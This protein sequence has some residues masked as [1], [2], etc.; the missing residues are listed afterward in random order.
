[1][2]MVPCITNLYNNIQRD[3]SLAMLEWSGCL[4]NKYYLTV[5][6]FTPPNSPGYMTIP[7]A[8][9]TVSY[10]PDDGCKSTQNMY[11]IT[12]VK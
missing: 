1:M 4:S 12:A 3:A 5:F 11:S 8:V 9:T 2:F 7:V 10:T 6:T